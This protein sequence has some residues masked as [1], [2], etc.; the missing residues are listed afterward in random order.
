MRLKA[1]VFIAG[2]CGGSIKKGVKPI[3]WEKSLYF[4]CTLAP[5]YDVY[6]PS[7]EALVTVVTLSS[8]SDLVV[9]RTKMGGSKMAVLEPS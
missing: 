4:F 1:P 2:Y 3:A 6:I 5:K 8:S 9:K 7:V